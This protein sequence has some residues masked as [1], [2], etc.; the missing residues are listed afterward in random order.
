MRRPV[1]EDACSDVRGVDGDTPKG[2]EG[3]V[4]HAI[5]QFEAW[6]DAADESARREIVE[7]LIDVLIGHGAHGRP[8]LGHN[9][10]AYMAFGPLSAEERDR[11]LAPLDSLLD[12]DEQ[13]QCQTGE[14]LMNA[15]HRDEGGPTLAEQVYGAPICLDPLSDE[16][17]R[18]ATELLRSWREGSDEDAEEQRITGEVIERALETDPIRFREVD[19]G[20]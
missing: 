7:R 15:L 8:I 13:E 11:A 20:W 5:E 10:F 3:L 9:P 2:R 16:E 14:Y 18:L 4:R 12:D 19:L 6:R 1:E 17:T